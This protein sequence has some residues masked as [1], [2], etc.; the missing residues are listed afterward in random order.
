MIVLPNIASMF[1]SESLSP[2]LVANPV[3]VETLAPASAVVIESSGIRCVRHAAGRI[4]AIRAS[5]GQ[6]RTNW[7]ILVR[8]IRRWEPARFLSP[9]TPDEYAGILRTG[10]A[11]EPATLP[12]AES[13]CTTNLR[14]APLGSTLRGSRGTRGSSGAVPAACQRKYPVRQPALDHEVPACFRAIKK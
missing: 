7:A 6:L 9:S 12:N 4:F 8:R 2:L 3:P 10:I 11:R 5:S 13:F 1:I 14:S